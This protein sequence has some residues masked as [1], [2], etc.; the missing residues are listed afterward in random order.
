MNFY[1]ELFSVFSMDEFI[2]V[3]CDDGLL[4]ALFKYCLLIILI[5]MISPFLIIGFPFVYLN[6][7]SKK[8]FYV[9]DENGE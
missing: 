7:K 4:V 9:D 1:K 3:V 8:W 2:S 6:T 5:L